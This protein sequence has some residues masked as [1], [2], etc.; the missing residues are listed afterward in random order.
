M[1]EVGA[2][3]EF[4][5]V[6]GVMPDAVV[7]AVGYRIACPSPVIHRGLPSP[8]LTVVLS[9]DD[10][11]VT[12]YSPGHARGKDAYRN[13]V[14][15]GGLHTTPA[16]IA[17]PELQ[18]G[19]QLAVRP[20]EARTLFGLPAGELAELTTEGADVL[21]DSVGRLR[22]QL[23]ELG[24]WPERFAALNRY[25][26]RRR[27]ATR[28]RPPR[29]E[30]VEAWKWIA[31]HRG[32][33][34]MKGLAQHVLLSQRQLTT[35]FRAEFGLTPKAVARLMRFEHARQHLTR[36]VRDG[37]HTDIAAVAHACGYFDHSHLVRDF[38]Q[39]TGANPTRWMAEER[40]NIQA[41]AHQHSEVWES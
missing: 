34:S 18:S 35:V 10:P 37:T 4:V 6:S 17:Q 31:W 5:N 12:G 7:S 32:T 23:A 38:R 1:N 22:E 15:L 2:E 29:A 13:Q 11:I 28:R 9:L 8:A 3:Q 24:T 33:G 21:G 26:H 40:Q 36:A 19:I 41:G 27:D 16:Y 20:Q 25:L 30:V 39:Y 14:V